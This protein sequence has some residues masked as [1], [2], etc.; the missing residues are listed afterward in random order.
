MQNSNYE[1]IKKTAHELNEKLKEVDY[2]RNDPQNY[3][4]EYFLELRNEVELRRENF[5]LQIDE[6]SNQLIDELRSYEEQ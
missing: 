5:K 6:Y 3:V 4:Y 2:L 1:L